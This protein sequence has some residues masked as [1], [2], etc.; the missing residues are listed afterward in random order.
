MILPLPWHLYLMALLYILAGVNH[1]VKP[2]MYI[3]I[4]P[5]SFPKPALL[6]KISGFAEIILG[7]LLCLPAFTKFA[8]CGIIV[9]LIA[10]FPAN[11]YMYQNPKAGFGL[12][13]YMLFLRLP[14][15]ALLMIWAC[16]YIR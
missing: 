12:P 5:P 13:K 4:I 8:A 14:L 10:V 7:I 9:L 6:N 2:R 11:L 3:K 15:Q 1:F 16:L